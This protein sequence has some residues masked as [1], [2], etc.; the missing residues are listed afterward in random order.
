M[1]LYVAAAMVT[2]VVHGNLALVPYLA[3]YGCGYAY[4]ALYDVGYYLRL[5]VS[6]PRARRKLKVLVSKGE[7]A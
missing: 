1:M 3:L 5:S 7:Y 6:E 4:V 2:A